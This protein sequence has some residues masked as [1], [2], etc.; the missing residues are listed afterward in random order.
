MIESLFATLFFLPT[1]AVFPS[2][3]Q[4]A[5]HFSEFLRWGY[6]SNIGNVETKFPVRDSTR[7]IGD[8]SVGQTDGQCKI[9]IMCAIVLFVSEL[10]LIDAACADEHLSLVLASFANI[11]CSYEHFENPAHFF[12]FSLRYF[13]ANKVFNMLSSVSDVKLIM[14]SAVVFCLSESDD[15]AFALLRNCLC[16][17]RED[18]TKPSGNRSPAQQCDRARKTT[19]QRK[20]F[21]FKRCADSSSQ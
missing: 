16:F 6:K 15:L 11:R 12:L 7:A 17:C 10:Q 21:C 4:V 18:A 3:T 8:F 14:F 9:I 2:N 20:V 19:N 5:V 13:L 1:P